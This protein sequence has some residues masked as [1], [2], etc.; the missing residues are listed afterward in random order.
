MMTGVNI[1]HVP[2]RGS[3][4][5]LSDLLGGQVH[6]MFG[7]VSSSIEYIRGGKLRALAVTSATRLEALPD[8]LPTVSEFVPDY[9][10]SQWYGIGAPK[11][12]PAEVVERLNAE[13]NSALAD[14]KMKARLADLGGTPLAGS[15]AD[16]GKLVADETDKWA[17]VVKFSGAKPD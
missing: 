15:P 1:I 2:Y 3:A 6:G 8:V 14:S 10:A 7:A 5:A 12:T 4:P 11:H 16:F 13:V 9:E 17:K